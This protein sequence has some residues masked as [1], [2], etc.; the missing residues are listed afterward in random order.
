[1]DVLLGSVHGG[2]IVLVRHLGTLASDR[3]SLAVAYSD[4]VFLEPAD[5]FGNRG[6][7]GGAAWIRHTE[8]NDLPR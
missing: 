3:L 5:G 7:P 8:K 6:E 1:M 4:G 2:P